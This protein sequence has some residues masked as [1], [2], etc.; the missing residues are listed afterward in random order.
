ME[1]VDQIGYV[2]TG[3]GPVPELS[4]DVPQEA[5]V[6][7]SMRMIEPAAAE[8]PAAENVE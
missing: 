3:A 6:I 5:V 7:K 2:D 8:P 4:Q 1:T